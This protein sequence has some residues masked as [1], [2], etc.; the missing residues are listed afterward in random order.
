ML[1]ESALLWLDKGANRPRRRRLSWTSRASI[2]RT[3]ELQE[4]LVRTRAREKRASIWDDEKR[5]IAAE[6]A[7]ERRRLNL[8]SLGTTRFCVAWRQTGVATR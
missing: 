2:A 6:K 5:K 4:W 3:G 7:G 8:I 1:F